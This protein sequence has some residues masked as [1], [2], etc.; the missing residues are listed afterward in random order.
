MT[1]KEKIFKAVE[2]S[3]VKVDLKPK[4]P[5]IDRIMRLPTEA[6]RLEFFRRFDQTGAFDRFQ[7]V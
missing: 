5:L 2:P 7:G 4:H 1:L 3:K 6:Q